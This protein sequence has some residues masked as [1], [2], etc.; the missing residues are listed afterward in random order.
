MCCEDRG[1]KNHIEEEKDR[2]KGRGVCFFLRCLFVVEVHADKLPNNRQSEGKVF[3]SGGK[4]GMG[5][6]LNRD[7]LKMVPVTMDDRLIRVA[8]REAL[9]VFG[10]GERRGGVRLGV[11]IT[12]RRKRVE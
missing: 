2:R 12:E 11:S 4:G 1:V 7:H 8:G 3:S 6:G 5:V 10:S 9:I